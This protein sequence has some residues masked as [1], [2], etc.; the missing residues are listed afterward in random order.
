MTPHEP[1]RPGDEPHPP[2]TPRR[3]A[4][5]GAGQARRHGGPD[6]ARRFVGRVALL[7]L[8]AV[9]AIADSWHRSMREGSDAWF[10]AEE[11][12]GQAVIMSGR[13]GQQRPLLMAV[14][15]VFANS[16]WYGPAAR[17]GGAPPERR[18]GATEATGQYLTTLAMLALLVRD[19]LEPPTFELLYQPFAVP[20]PPAE[21][22]AE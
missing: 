5:E 2:G 18:V 19:H 9:R 20:I 8:G 22:T 15:D 1:G 7:D 21:L 16:V 17:S 11:A 4:G 6:V 12:V 13:H 10:A 3:P 14:A